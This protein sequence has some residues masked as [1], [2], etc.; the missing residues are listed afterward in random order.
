MA[1]SGYDVW[2]ISTAIKMH[3]GGSYDAF[4]YNFKAKSLSHAAYEKRNEKIFYTALGS[5]IKTEEELI[6]YVF[7][8][9]VF[10]SNDFIRDMNKDCYT[11]YL[12]RIE[13]LSYRFKGDIKALN[14]NGLDDLLVSHDG[15]IPKIVQAYLEG[16][17][18]LET[19]VIID[20]LTNF[21]KVANSKISDVLLWQSVCN[22]LSKSR[23]FIRKEINPAKYR[24]LVVKEFT[25]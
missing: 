20:I 16:K 4:Q 2:R 23:P 8:N 10:G 19:V 24:A 25:I 5:R 17:I 22:L 15:A 14:E 3:F 1:L 18:M 11:E 21:I 6:R 7:A 9:I 13:T 12:S